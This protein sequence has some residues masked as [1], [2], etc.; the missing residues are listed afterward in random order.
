MAMRMENWAVRLNW[1]RK[2]CQDLYFLRRAALILRHF[3]FEF[4]TTEINLKVKSCSRINFERLL[5]R[6]APAKLEASKNWNY[7]S[8]KIESWPKVIALNYETIDESRTLCTSHHFVFYTENKV[9]LSCC[10][11]LQSYLMEWVEIAQWVDI[12]CSKS[13][14][15]LK[16]HFCI[17]NFF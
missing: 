5:A 16:I 3:S 6:A 8:E 15:S 4:G 10:L 2:M 14:Y 7:L 11:Q 17:D 1:L 9:D 12:E 13:H